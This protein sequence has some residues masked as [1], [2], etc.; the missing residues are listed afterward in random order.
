MFEIVFDV[1][2]INNMHISKMMC[3]Q[4]PDISDWSKEPLT[5]APDM[6]DVFFGDLPNKNFIV[7]CDGI[8]R[9]KVNKVLR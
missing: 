2:I 5:T 7:L 9:A 4:H 3:L 8:S 1:Y 6:A